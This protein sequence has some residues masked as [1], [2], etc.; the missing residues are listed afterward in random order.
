L[1]GAGANFSMTLQVMSALLRCH[2]GA[3]RRWVFN[4]V[5]WLGGNVVHILAI[6]AIFLS[7]KY[8]GQEVQSTYLGILIAFVL[9]YVTTHVTLEIR[10]KTHSPVMNNVHEMNPVD[11]GNTQKSGDDSMVET[12]GNSKLDYSFR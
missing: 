9:S 2:P 4:T 10:N 6:T 7:S 12:V 3:P 11:N 8:L 5:H 1:V